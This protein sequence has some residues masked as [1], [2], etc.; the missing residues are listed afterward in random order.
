MQDCCGNE[1]YSKGIFEAFREGL[2]V[3]NIMITLFVICALYI[4][5][6]LLS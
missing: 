1:H 3:N 5:N 6:K 2:Y 4:L